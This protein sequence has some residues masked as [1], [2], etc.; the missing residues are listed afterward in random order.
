MSQVS[1]AAGSRFLSLLGGTVLSFYDW[2]ADLPSASPEVWGEQT[3]AHES[4][5]WY[6]SR[7][8]AVM[9]SNLN[10]TRTPDCHFA[11]EVRFAGA[12]LSVFSPDFSQIAKHADYWI[13][14][15]A[16][17]GRRIL[18]GR[19]P[20]ALDRVLRAARRRP[21]LPITSSNTR[22]HPSWSRSRL[23]GK[24]RW[25]GQGGW[26]APTGWQIMRKRRTATGSS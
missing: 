11:T 2:Y 8:I 18:D 14:V 17:A 3:D 12:K 25:H 23:P 9:G 15:R 10:M 26:C 1:Y 24:A 4:A 21:I 22:T 5:D 19:E 13:P 7:F 6:N 16:G 20:R